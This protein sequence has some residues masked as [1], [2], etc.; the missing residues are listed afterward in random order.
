MRHLRRARGALAALLA[1]TLLPALTAAPVARA[2]GYIGTAMT[3][4]TAV[5]PA[6][7]MV[8]VA[9]QQTN[10]DQ[11]RNLRLLGQDFQAQPGFA[12]LLRTALQSAGMSSASTNG[13][14]NQLSAFLGRLFNGE[15]GMAVLP[16]TTG[17]G[18]QGRPVPQLHVLLEAGL[19]KGIDAAQLDGALALFGLPVKV[20]S[21]YRKLPIIAFDLSKLIGSSVQGSGAGTTGVVPTMLYGVIAGNDAVLA[22]DMPTLRQAIDTWY[23]T[24]PSIAGTADF[25]ATVGALPARRFLT[26]YVNL[27]VQA[28]VRLARTLNVSPQSLA[29]LD[30]PGHYAAATSMTA[31]S[32]GIL[33]SVSPQ[34]RTGALAAGVGLTPT[35]LAETSF[36]PDD[37][38][39]YTAINDPGS[40]IMRALTA[41]TA[42]LRASQRCISANGVTQCNPVQQPDPAQQFE[43]ATGLNLDNDILSWMHGDASLA[44]LPV[45]SAA[46]GADTPLT[47]LS[48]VATIKVENQGFVEAKIAKINAALQ[49]LA[50][51][52]GALALQWVD[53][54][55]A[56]GQPLHMLAA[57]P[58]GIG[59]TFYH[60]YLLLGTALPTDVAA[61]ER[62]SA[63]Q[64]LRMSPLYRAAFSHLGNQPIGTVLFVN[65]GHLRQTLE[66]VAAAT[67]TDT[68]GYKQA[69][70]L[71][72]AFKSLAVVTYAGANAGGALFIGIGR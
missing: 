58:N 25:Q 29:G 2:G 30:R 22:T 4:F 40:L 56:N 10:P 63:G 64:N 51:P 47:R 67:G 14:I 31:E 68:T 28:L 59:Y 8:Y 52:Q 12:A 60:G 62:G 69:R 16:V 55:G 32:D 65:I 18:P 42:A 61:L 26:D 24:S 53:V 39:V 9:V 20:E 21:T 72:T 49:K 23:G 17:T 19:Q 37:T 70:P 3:D 36:L 11:G 46:F 34:I 6:S 41:A 1:L 35:Q 48:L 50:G 5:T 43:R 38:L 13:A 44:L 71:V 15:F 7:A 57:T 66:E 54:Q 45:G 33:Y 27:D